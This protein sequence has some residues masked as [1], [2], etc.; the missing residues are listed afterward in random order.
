MSYNFHLP[1]P[2]TSLLPGHF[3]CCKSFLYFFL[4]FLKLERLFFTIVLSSIEN[5]DQAI[6][7]KGLDPP[8]VILFDVF[9]K[10]WKLAQR[11]SG[12]IDIIGYENGTGQYFST[13]YISLILAYTNY[14]QIIVLNDALYGFLS[15]SIGS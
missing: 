2:R 15:L 14:E 12:V 3:S 11:A 8:P 13:A 1:Q 4:T 7:L 5:S 9:Q 6:F 10:F